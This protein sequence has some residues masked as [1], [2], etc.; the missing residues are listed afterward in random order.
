MLCHEAFSGV[1]LARR[2]KVLWFAM[3][4]HYPLLTRLVVFIWWVLLQLVAL[5]T[6]YR[7]TAFKGGQSLA[8]CSPGMTLADVPQVCSMPRAWCNVGAASNE[9]AVA[10]IDSELE[11]LR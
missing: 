5:G 9:Q 2:I 6:A 3:T 1:L 11:K 8:R 7:Q 4:P 10:A